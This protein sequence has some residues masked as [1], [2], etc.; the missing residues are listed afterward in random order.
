M[1]KRVE[2]VAQQILRNLD[3]RVIITG[4]EFEINKIKDLLRD[5]FVH[6]G[7]WEKFNEVKIQEVLSYDTMT[8][9]RNVRNETRELED[10][11]RVIVPTSESHGYRVGWAF[12]RLF[13][14][15]NTVSIPQSQDDSVLESEDGRIETI[16]DKESPEWHNKFILELLK[17]G[18]S[19]AK[20]AWIAKNIY[21]SDI[22]SRIVQ[23]ASIAIRPGKFVNWYLKPLLKKKAGEQSVKSYL[24]SCFFW[25]NKT[26]LSA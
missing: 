11:D 10:F 12:E 1:K 22:G 5:A 6:L 20:Y 4:Y 14:D 9:I 8:N 19:E 3:S 25:S 16:F 23:Y 15:F 13:K 21:R 2:A 18:E 17:S 7:A 26:Y 24:L